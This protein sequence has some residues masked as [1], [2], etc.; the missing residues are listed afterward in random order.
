MTKQIC[1]ITQKYK[2]CFYLCEGQE[3]GVHPRRGQEAGV[4]A[5][6]GG[7]EPVPGL[8]QRGDIEDAETSVFSLA[9]S[10]QDQNSAFYSVA[11]TLVPRT[12][13]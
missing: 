10:P 2:L 1:T 9:A 4:K 3:A 6:Q 11:L 13:T 7:L 12:I 5:R 8:E